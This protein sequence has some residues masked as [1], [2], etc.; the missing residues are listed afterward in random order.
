VI[1]AFYQRAADVEPFSIPRLGS[2][3][4]PQEIA[5]P[6]LCEI[7]GLGV[8]PDDTVRGKT[9]TM[10]QALTRIGSSREPRRDPACQSWTRGWSPRPPSMVHGSRRHPRAVL[11]WT[12]A[13]WR[14]CSPLGPSYSDRTDSSGLFRVACNLRPRRGDSMSDANH[15]HPEP[16]APDSRDS[17][18]ESRALLFLGQRQVLGRG[19]DAGK[20]RKPS[21]LAYL[22]GL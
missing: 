1:V 8:G 7:S 11:T 22:R 13:D 21:G 17:S 2:S 4:S 6:M 16:P 20:A 10:R 19:C 15:S 18:G 3:V 9:S 12:A 14:G 5:S